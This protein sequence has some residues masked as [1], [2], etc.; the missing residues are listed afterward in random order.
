[1]SRE[2][3]KI[4]SLE[5]EIYFVKSVGLAAN[6]TKEFASIVSRNGTIIKTIEGLP[7]EIPMTD[8]FIEKLRNMAKDSLYF[9]HYHTS[10]CSFSFDDLNTLCGLRSIHQMIIT[11]PA[12]K[13]YKMIASGDIIPSY[14]LLLDE[15][16]ILKNAIEKKLDKLV[17][18]GKMTIAQRD[19]ETSRELSRILKGRYEW[20]YNE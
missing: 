5:Q 19:I 2:G 18:S 9:I 16:T 13:I 17:F 1:L 3:Q 15:W 11:T 7:R 10:G 20:R 12:G 14:E 8:E 4:D 6:N